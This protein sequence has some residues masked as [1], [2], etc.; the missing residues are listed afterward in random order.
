MSKTRELQNSR[1]KKTKN[2]GL[3][4]QAID[5]PEQIRVP[6]CVSKKAWWKCCRCKCRVKQL[7]ITSVYWPS[8]HFSCFLAF[9]LV[10]TLTPL[11]GKMSMSLRQLE[12]EMSI[13]KD[14]H[15]IN[16]ESARHCEEKLRFMGI[17]K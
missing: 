5:T 9:E 11:A 4:T 13:V 12:N 2:F 6:I 17:L 10:V 15:E 1:R 16:K 8:A 7:F 3:K 14:G